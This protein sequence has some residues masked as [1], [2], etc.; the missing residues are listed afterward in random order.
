MSI[1][2]TLGISFVFLTAGSL[3]PTSMFREGIQCICQC[4]CGQT[5][6]QVNTTSQ[7]CLYDYST[8]SRLALGSQKVLSDMLPE[9]SSL[10]PKSDFSY[11]K[12][13]Y[14][15]YNHW[16]AFQKWLVFNDFFL[17]FHIED[18]AHLKTNSTFHFITLGSP[19]RKWNVQKTILY[20]CILFFKC[21]R[22]KRCLNHI[23]HDSG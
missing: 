9:L 13:K 20:T 19:D 3:A 7:K 23:F 12:E 14:A 21:K 15:S 18:F 10:T 16:K 22:T 17:K 8:V 2:W 5:D 6:P 11:F 4:T 1:P